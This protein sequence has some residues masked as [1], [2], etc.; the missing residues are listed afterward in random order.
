MMSS[1]AFAYKLN[2]IYA[3]WVYPK[4]FCW[5]LWSC[6]SFLRIEPP[7]SQLSGV[8]SSRSSACKTVSVAFPL[9]AA[10]WS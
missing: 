3:F 10:T 2:F 6:W 7:R 8:L 5:I 9:S 1:K 4:K